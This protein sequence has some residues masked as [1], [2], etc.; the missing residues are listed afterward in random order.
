MQ[1]SD[2]QAFVEVVV[3]FAE[4]K[5]KQLSAPALELYWKAMKDWT[6]DEFQA[7]AGRLLKTSEFMPTPL[8]LE[9]LRKAGRPTTGE[10]WGMA[11]E[12]AKGAWRQ[13]DCGDPLVDKV[14]RF[15]GGYREIAHCPTTKLGFLERRFCEHYENLETAEDTRLAVPELTNDGTALRR[16]AGNGDLKLLDDCP[17]NMDDSKDER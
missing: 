14:V 2:R 17:L 16:L 12:H 15:L 6:L 13:G 4:L 9:E 7:A 10:A 8:N 1:A 11:L 3:G 5:G